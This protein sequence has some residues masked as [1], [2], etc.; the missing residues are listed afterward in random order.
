MGSAAWG[1][2][3]CR[4]SQGRVSV[5]FCRITCANV[6]LRVCPGVL[7]LME[8]LLASPRDFLNPTL[9]EMVSQ[10]G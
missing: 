8:K 7:G 2:L 9:P 5:R 3:L 6:T 10:E 4:S 1:E